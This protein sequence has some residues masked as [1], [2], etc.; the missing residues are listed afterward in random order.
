MRAKQA[1]YTRLRRFRLSTMMGRFRELFRRNCL[2]EYDRYM[3]LTM[4]IYIKIECNIFTYLGTLNI[5]D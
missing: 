2:A 1:E 3:L 4:L 5:K